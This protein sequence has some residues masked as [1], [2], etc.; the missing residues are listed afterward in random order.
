[1]ASLAD[2]EY[3]NQLKCMLKDNAELIKSID[4]AI[5]SY[6]RSSCIVKEYL[7]DLKNRDLRRKKQIELENQLENL[8]LKLT[9][10]TTNG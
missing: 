5:Q 1:M 10:S 3:Y 6:E 9:S 4:E 7:T 8:K 2:V